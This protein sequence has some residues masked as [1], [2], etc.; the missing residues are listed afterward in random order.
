MCSDEYE[1]RM[2]LATPDEAIKDV[3]YQLRKREQRHKYHLQRSNLPWRTEQPASVL[4]DPSVPKHLF[5]VSDRPE[6]YQ[7][8]GR[9]MGKHSIDTA[10]R[11]L[12]HSRSAVPVDQREVGYSV[13]DNIGHRESVVGVE[14]DD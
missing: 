13:N 9:P 11:G 5:D 4:P 1:I 3:M 7:K 14:S 6:A 2:V 8:D 12:F 10:A